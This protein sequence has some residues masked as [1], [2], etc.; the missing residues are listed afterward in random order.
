MSERTRTV[1]L[2]LVAEV[3]LEEPWPEVVTDDFLEAAAQRQLDAFRES[4]QPSAE[5]GI[6]FY[7]MRFDELGADMKA[8]PTGFVALQQEGS[9]CS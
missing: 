4:V 2:L 5:Y 1:R 3:H 8:S 9:S 6:V 7:R